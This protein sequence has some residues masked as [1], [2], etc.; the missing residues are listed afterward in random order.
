MK[1]N[2]TDIKQEGN[3]IVLKDLGIY[4]EDPEQDKKINEDLRNFLESKGYPRPRIKT[5]NR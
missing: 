2:K 3:I 5:R 1:R 4:S